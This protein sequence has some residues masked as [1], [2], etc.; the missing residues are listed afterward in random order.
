LGFYGAEDPSRR[1]NDLILFAVGSGYHNDAYASREWEAEN[2]GQH[3]EIEGREL[4][5]VEVQDA[6][7]LAFNQLRHGERWTRIRVLLY[8]GRGSPA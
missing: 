6:Q 8:C 2:M 4:N 5:F 7:E 3:V 1:S